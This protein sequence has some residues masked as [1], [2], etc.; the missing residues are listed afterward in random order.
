MNNKVFIFLGPG[1][2]VTTLHVSSLLSLPIATRSHNYQM[3]E[4]GLKLR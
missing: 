2:M 3:V 4:P 1:A